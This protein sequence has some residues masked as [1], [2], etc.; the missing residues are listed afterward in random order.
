MP[1]TESDEDAT[2]VGATVVGATVIGATVI[3]AT[4]PTAARSRLRQTR[5]Q[6][7]V[8]TSNIMQ[9][10]AFG[11]IALLCLTAILAPYVVPY[12]AAIGGQVSMNEILEAPSWTHPF[13]TDEFGRD[14][15]SRVLYGVRVSLM[16]SVIV[17]SIAIGLGS[18]FGVIAAGVGGIVDEV[19]MRTTDIFLAFPV[20]VLAIV[21]TSFWGGSLRNA[22]IA[23]G[24]S[25]WPW[26]ARLV[27]GTALSIRERPYVI[28]A[29]ALGTS[30][31]RVMFSHILKNSLGPTL[32]LASLDMGAVILML[33]TLSFLGLGAQPPTPEWGLM[34]NQSRTYFLS[35]WWYMAF[36]GLAITLTVFSFSILGEGLGEVL[37][38]K[39][40][41][42][43]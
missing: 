38:P 23:L 25:W 18:A 11:F 32:V 19:I 31:L 20:A 39:S 40:R 26:Y 35:A 10:A 7:H 42:Q 5:L 9:K 15:F 37:N 33:A 22:I 3:G 34:I 21:I 43:G 12:P 16:A 14:I 24:I 30:P 27:R 1:V 8:L 41:G 29:R 28:A 6:W 13:G 2:V 36:P 17:I 4:N